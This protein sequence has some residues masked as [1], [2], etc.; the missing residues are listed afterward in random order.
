M[1]TPYLSEIRAFGFAFAPRGWALCN[2]QL[3]PI[4]QNQAL[5]ALL[6]TQYGGD[7]RTTFALPDLRGRVA[8]S[9]GNG[10]AQGQAAGSESVAL[11]AGQLPAHSHTI[12]AAANGAGNATN[13]PG[14]TVVL[15]SGSSSQVGNLPVSIYGSGAPVNLA[16]LGTAGG[17][18]PHENRM[19]SLV[20]NYC[21][22]LEGIFPSRS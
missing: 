6:G 9:P 17:N 5:F 19:P 2:G 8:I 18:T 22:A 15:G 11:T 16:P 7:G 12:N 10:L 20:M 13:I 1:A 14:P 21:I 3:L 4:S